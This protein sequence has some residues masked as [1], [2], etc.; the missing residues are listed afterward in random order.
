[1]GRTA[2]RDISAVRSGLGGPAG[3]VSLCSGGKWRDP[4]GL[5]SHPRNRL[6]QNRAFLGCLARNQSEASGGSRFLQGM[7][8]HLSFRTVLGFVRKFRYRKIV[9]QL[10]TDKPMT[11]G[12]RACLSKERVR[13]F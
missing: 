8:L 7:Q 9:L 4:G 11:F 6:P 12:V 3:T 13:C 2:P 5:K 1:M 10:K